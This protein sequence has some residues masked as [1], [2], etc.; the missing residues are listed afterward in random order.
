MALK[1]GS[2]YKLKRN[3]FA[4]RERK[5]W[6]DRRVWLDASKNTIYA[7]LSKEKFSEKLPAVPPYVPETVEE[8]MCY[9]LLSTSGSIYYLV[10][11][12]KTR[13]YLEKTAFEE[14]IMP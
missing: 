1:I 9:K 8:F 5:D 13:H 6:A 4:S 14:V 12:Y 3:F 7:L 2:L 11:R 10:K